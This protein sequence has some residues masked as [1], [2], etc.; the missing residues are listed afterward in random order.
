MYPFNKDHTICISMTIYIKLV[1]EKKMELLKEEID[2][3]LSNNQ[4]DSFDFEGV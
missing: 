3:V 1:I 4:L 2:I